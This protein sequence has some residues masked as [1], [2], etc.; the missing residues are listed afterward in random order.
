MITTPSV[1]TYAEAKQL[2]HSG[3][4]VAFPTETVYGLGAN[5]LDTEAV[6]KIFTTKGRPQTNPII[7]HLGDVDQIL[8]YAHIT[9]P[10][11]Q[12]I[13]EKLMPGPL[14]ILLHK[15]PNVPDMVTAGSEFVG[16]RIPQ[17]Q[18]ARELLIE[19]NL[20]IAAPSANVS[21]KPS[22][23]TAAMVRDNFGDK[24]PMIIDGGDCE[25]G[26]ESTVVKVEGDR[27]IITRPGY[28]TK[29]DLESI[30]PSSVQ[31]DYATTV[32][33]IT[34]GNMFKHYSPGAKVRIFENFPTTELTH[35]APAGKLLILATTE[36]IEEYQSQLAPYASNITVWNRGTKSNLISCA[37]NL[38]TMYHQADNEHF[39]EIFIE[40]LPEV[41]LGY[42]IMNR[43]KKSAE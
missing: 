18:V 30:L 43:V 42:A 11:E 26:I 7:V 38:F 3:N 13:I 8:D 24:V 27:V 21:T 22:P 17:N 2:L 14:T 37:H 4:L 39:S 23:T 16:I 12:L 36:R 31:V 6:S 25:V 33:E 34:P 28:I 41:G 9:S 15:K 29:E 32:S 20:P 10:W 35:F 40:Q 19:V 1:Q 5:A